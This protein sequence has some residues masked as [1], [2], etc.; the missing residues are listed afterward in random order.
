MEYNVIRKFRDKE[1]FEVLEVGDSFVTDKKERA[2]ELQAKGF[3][4]EAIKTETPSILNQNVGEVKISITE[5]FSKEDLEKLLEQEVSGENRKGVKDHIESLLKGDK[6]E[7][8]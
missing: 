8:S 1:S 7:S 6:F 4:G 3:I 5:E 2:N